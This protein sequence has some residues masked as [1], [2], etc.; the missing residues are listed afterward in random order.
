M[1]DARVEFILAHSDPLDV[2]NAI[3]AVVEGFT[4]ETFYEVASRGRSRLAGTYRDE[5]NEVLALDPPYVREEF[6]KFLQRNPRALVCFGTPLTTRV[7]ARLQDTSPPFFGEIAVADRRVWLYAGAIAA[8]F[9]LGVAITVIVTHSRAPVEAASHRST[10]RGTAAVRVQAVHKQQSAPPVISRRNTDEVVTDNSSL[11]A[12]PV[13]S[14]APKG[15]VQQTVP[16][17]AQPTVVKRSTPAPAPPNGKG[18]AIVAVPA[19]SPTATPDDGTIDAENDTPVWR[20]GTVN[21]Q[22]SPA[23][24]PSV[25]DDGVPHEAKAIPIHTATPLPPRPKATQKPSVIRRVLDGLK[26]K[27]SPSSSP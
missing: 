12:A 17:A 1:H 23:D 22:A 26:P 16:V 9:V 2:A 7:S 5:L 20:K 13:T 25:Q 18:D 11:P 24:A 19:P 15:E 6:S 10:L 8:A 14:D 3:E 21:V 4:W 27:P